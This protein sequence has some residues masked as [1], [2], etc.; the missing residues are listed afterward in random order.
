F[1]YWEHRFIPTLLAEPDPKAEKL[2]VPLEQALCMYCRVASCACG[3][4]A[5][6]P[7]GTRRAS[8]LAVEN[9]WASSLLHLHAAQRVWCRDARD[10]GDRPHAMSALWRQPPHAPPAGA[11][12]DVRCQPRGSLRGAML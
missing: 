5:S 9:C 4:T 8:C 3:I 1:A 10:H 12:P 7:T 11:P 2:L 6:S